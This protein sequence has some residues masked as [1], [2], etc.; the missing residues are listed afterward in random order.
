MTLDQFLAYRGLSGAGN[1]TSMAPEQV[2]QFTSSTMKA[3]LRQAREP[4]LE[5][6]EWRPGDMPPK[7][8]APV[9][10]ANLMK[11]P[12]LGYCEVDE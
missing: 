7:K 8:G 2:P 12:S 1:R 9:A 10:L 6:C 11:D 5:Y 4:W 3:W